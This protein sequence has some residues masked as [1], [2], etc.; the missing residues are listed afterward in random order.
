MNTEKNNEEHKLYN[1]S[2]NLII[3]ESEN[4]NISDV[5]GYPIEEIPNPSIRITSFR[6]GACNQKWLSSEYKIVSEPNGSCSFVKKD[7]SKP[8]EPSRTFYTRLMDICKKNGVKP[9][10]LLKS[11]GLSATNL[12][13]WQNG[14][15]VNSDIVKK[16]AAYFGVSPGY[17]FSED[18]EQPFAGSAL[19]KLCKSA[20]G[21]E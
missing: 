16:L 9:T 13:R 5:I 8:R 14:S 21:G 2:E 1:S 6:C 11:L 3:P 18:E 4:D 15:T 12:K 10:P 19:D 17:F 20:G 7:M